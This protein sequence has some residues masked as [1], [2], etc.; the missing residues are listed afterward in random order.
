MR[1][2]LNGAKPGPALAICGEM[3]SLIIP[4]H[5]ECDPATGLSILSA[6]QNGLLFRK[7]L[8]RDFHTRGAGFGKVVCVKSIVD[9]G[10]IAVFI[11]KTE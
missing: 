6:S 5:P 7:A 11:G 1:A 9:R 4:T 8:R 10:D 2:D 3:D